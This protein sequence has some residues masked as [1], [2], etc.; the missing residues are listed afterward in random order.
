MKT[1]VLS[2]MLSLT[3]GG[4]AMANHVVDDSYTIA[5]RFAGYRT[6][7]PGI[8]L[9]VIAPRTGQTMAFD[10]VYKTIGDRDLHIDIF[11][12]APRTSIGQGLVL[13]HGGAWR[14]GG[15]AHFYALANLLAQRGLTVFLPEFRLAPEKPFPAGMDDIADA[16]TWAQHEAPRYTLRADRIA[17]GGASSGGQMAALL[18]YRRAADAGANTAPPP[19]LPPNALIDMDGVLDAT[20]PLALQYEDAAKQDS[21]LAQWLGGAFAQRPD[22]WRDASA[23]RHAGPASPPTLIISSGTPR[24]TAGRERVTAIL[25]RHHIRTATY[26]YPRAP[27]DFWLFQPYLD[28][29]VVQ[30]SAFLASVDDDRPRKPRT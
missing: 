3:L 19:K 17:V 28:Q 29:A 30:I 2:A 8:A 12:P 1:L 6:E 25:Q 20:S 14:S 4:S 21:P 18:A 24:F 16:L 13:V 27:H 7:Y 22:V 11:S 15:K 9:P 23:A 26:I 10:L 5:R